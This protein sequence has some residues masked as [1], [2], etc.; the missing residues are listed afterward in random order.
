MT[1]QTPSAE[2]MVNVF[3]R[4]DVGRT[5]E[6]NEDSFVVADL[7][8]NVASLQ[9]SVRAHKS[10]P[11]GTLF[12]VADGMGGAAAG[13]IASQMATDIVLRE[14]RDNWLPLGQPSPEAFARCLK[15]A[16][17]SANQQIHSYATSHQEY[18]GMGTTATI[19]GFLEGILY[20]AQVGDSRGYLIRNGVV[21]QITKDQSL[22]QKL[23]EAGELTEEEAAQSERRNIIL[24]ALGPEAQ[25]KV[26]LTYQPVL[27]GDILLLC[28]DGLSGQITKDDIA[29]VLT[30]E[31][32]LVNACKKLIEIANTNGGPDNITVILSRFEGDGLPEAS[33]D[34]EAEDVGHKVFSVPDAGATPPMAMDRITEGPTSP[35]RPSDARPTQPVVSAETPTDPGTPLDGGA[36]KEGAAHA[37]TLDAIDV[38][39]DTLDMTPEKSSM[40]RI[41]V[42]GL[43]VLL[44][45]AAGWFGMKMMGGNAPDSAAVQPDSAAI[46]ADTA[47]RT[48][49]TKPDSA[50]PPP[51]AP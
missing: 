21:K 6:H 35:M 41:V 51:V 40:G 28:S 4:T 12:M 24:Q 20:L 15:R 3:G 16:A 31:P 39:A 25:I 10:G 18:R 7:N 46:P 22:M 50:T 23:I 32:D 11:K 27:K 43:A 17:Q 1:E 37:A 14:L 8:S 9:P 38:E 33:E 30:E 48:D 26:D 13:E 44:V 42:I 29:R 2:I 5:R 34:A 45:V 47:L 36:S 19:A 49:T